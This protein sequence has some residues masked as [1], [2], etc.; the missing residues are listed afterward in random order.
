VGGSGKRGLLFDWRSKDYSKYFVGGKATY[1]SN[2]HATRGETGATLDPSFAF[3]PTLIVDQSLQNANWLATVK[4]LIKGGVTTVFAYVVVPVVVWRRWR[5]QA[6]VV[7][8]DARSNEPDHPEQANL[9]PAQAAHV[10]KQYMMPLQGLG[11]SL[12]TPSITNGG[13]NYGLNYLEKFVTA[14]SGCVFNVINIHHYVQRSDVDVDGAVKALQEYIDQ[15]VPAV[16]R[17]H[18][19]LRGLKLFLGEVGHSDPIYQSCMKNST[20]LDRR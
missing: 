4:G 15:T 16:Q 14:C 20:P 11:A 2:W 18:P 3:I 8:L 5:V 9:S 13:G 1:A 10:Y 17:K 12:C 19:Q 7:I 6:D